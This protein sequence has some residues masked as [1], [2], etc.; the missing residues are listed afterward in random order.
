MSVFDIFDFATMEQFIL[1][2]H[3]VLNCFDDQELQ[4]KAL[5]FREK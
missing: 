4:E 3:Y 2:N 1:E 5:S